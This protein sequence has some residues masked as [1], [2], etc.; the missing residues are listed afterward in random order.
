[1]R[2]HPFCGLVLGQYGQWISP[3]SGS[4]HVHDYAR[5]IGC[6]RRI[7]IELEFSDNFDDHYVKNNGIKYR[8][9]LDTVL[10]LLNK[11]YAANLAKLGCGAPMWQIQASH[12][13]EIQV[14]WEVANPVHLSKQVLSFGRALQTLRMSG[15]GSVHVNTQFPASGMDAFYPHH[16]SQMGNY[17]C[18]N[19]YDCSRDRNEAIT[20]IENKYGPSFMYPEELLAKLLVAT[21]ALKVDRFGK[22]FEL[23]RTIDRELKFKFPFMVGSCETYLRGL[24]NYH[25][26]WEHIPDYYEK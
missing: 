17:H 22:A 13:K 16:G 11:A 10:G 15:L 21:V 2:H 19:K 20:R 12:S 14:L 5:W 4:H 25:R 24:I 6:R 18:H 26:M 8:V 3:K 1:M 9:S 7:G 23:A